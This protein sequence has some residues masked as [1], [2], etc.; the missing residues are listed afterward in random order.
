MQ[1]VEV[2]AKAVGP[3]A[4]AYLPSVVTDLVFLPEGTNQVFYGEEIGWRKFVASIEEKYSD[5]QG[6]AGLVDDFRRLGSEYV[7]VSL[8]VAN[9]DFRLITAKQLEELYECYYKVYLTYST[10]VWICY[11]L[12][13][14]FSEKA[15]KLLETKNKSNSEAAAALFRPTTEF[16]VLELKSKL[17]QIKRTSG[18][19]SSKMRDDLAEQY[20]WIPCLDLN[21]EPWQQKDI[22]D[23]FD[24]LELSPDSFSIEEA[25]KYYSLYLSEREFFQRVRDLI[26]V[27]DERDVYRRKGVYAVRS[28]YRTMAEKLGLSLREISLLTK[29]EIISELRSEKFAD[30]VEIAQRGE[31][32]A[33]KCENGRVRIIS[34]KRAIENLRK[35][36]TGGGT[37]ADGSISGVA[38]SSG[39]ATGQVVVVNGVADLRKVKKGNILVAVTTHPDFIL[40]MQKAVAFVT[41]EGGLAHHAAIVAREMKKPCITGTKIATKVLKDGDTVEVDATKGI[42]KILKHA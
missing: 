12:A 42:V 3:E 26:A 15:R 24:H 6:M 28:F 14:V 2:A 35:T 11:Y 18:Q 25:E 5:P 20:A 22:Q 16:A 8:E 19:L 7:R 10:L 33:A 31:S 37:I 40:A 38:A 32:F 30:K 17:G 41:D 27:K 4:S 39:Y 23:I 29:A 34:G 13:E 9:S 1:Y 36:A 21:D